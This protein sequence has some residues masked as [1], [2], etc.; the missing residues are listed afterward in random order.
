[1]QYLS[2]LQLRALRFDFPEVFKDLFMQAKFELDATVRA[3]K[4][5]LELLDEIDPPLRSR[6]TVF[7]KPG[8][9][10]RFRLSS[11][12]QMRVLMRRLRT[13]KSIKDKLS[14]KSPQDSERALR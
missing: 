1:M 3:K 10:K 11:R 14:E 9:K 4:R 12:N 6:K 13:R 7:G 2:M 8:P 5:G